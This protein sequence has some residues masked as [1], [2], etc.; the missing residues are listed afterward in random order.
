MLQNLKA[1][2]ARYSISRKEIAW[3]LS[4]SEQ[5]VSNKIRGVCEFTVT[6]AIMIHQKY[7]SKCDF[8]F[9]FSKGVTCK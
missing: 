3:C 5:T 4:V 1:E 6:E 8:V 2:M 7:F 9:L